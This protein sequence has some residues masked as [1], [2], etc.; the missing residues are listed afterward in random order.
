MQT[1]VVV[2]NTD[3][4]P[5]IVDGSYKINAEDSS[6]SWEDGNKVEH[7]I[8]VKEKVKG[9]FEVVCSNRTGS[10]TLANFLSTWNGAV[11]NKVVTLGC[12]VLNTGAFE[13]INAYFKIENT[14]HDLAA[15]GS[16]IDKLKITITER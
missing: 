3:I 9:S 5:Y 4:T 8:V 7:R 13:A 10:I 16:F 1:H 15:D 2:N 14:L 12:R 11:S 6:E